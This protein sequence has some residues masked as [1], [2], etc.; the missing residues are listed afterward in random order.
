[1]KSEAYYSVTGV[2]PVRVGVLKYPL[3]TKEGVME[4]ACM[5]QKK[6]TGGSGL[7]NFLDQPSTSFSFIVASPTFA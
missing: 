2:A 7:E 6:G 3:E 1:M 4:T 5:A